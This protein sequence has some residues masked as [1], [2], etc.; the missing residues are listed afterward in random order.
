MQKT[1]NTLLV[2]ALL[3][4]AASSEAQERENE[5]FNFGWRFH[6][7]EVIGGE[8]PTLD[9]ADWKSLD[10]PYDY[11]LNQPW[12]ETASRARGFK[13]QASGWFRKTFDAPEAWRGKPVKQAFE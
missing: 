11:Q 3:G 4:M 13:E 12:V 7:G 6:L 5:L 9:D 10:L 1:F 2:L 8:A